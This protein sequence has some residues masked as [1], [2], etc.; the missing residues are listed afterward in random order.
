MFFWVGG[1]LNWSYNVGLW[2]DRKYIIVINGYGD[3][4]EFR[5]DGR[6]NEYVIE[7]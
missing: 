1:L 7:V 5:E 2:F 3:D 4:E 6:S